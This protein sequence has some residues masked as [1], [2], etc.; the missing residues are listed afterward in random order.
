M[1]LARTLAPRPRLLLCDEPVSALDLPNRQTL[2]ERLRAVQHSEG[3]PVLYVTHSP[4]EA[5]AVGTRLF[6]LERGR[7]P[8]RRPAAGRPGQHSRPIVQPPRRPPQYPAGPR[9]EPVAGA[10]RHPAPAREWAVSDRALSRSGTGHA[11]HR[12]GSRRGHPSG[13]RPDL[14]PE[15]QN[16]IPGKVER[17]ITHGP[18]AEALI[19]TGDVTWIVSLVAPAVEQ[20]ALSPGQDVH[21]IIK[22]RSCHVAPGSPPRTDR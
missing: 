15:A 8:R 20:L 4:A 11:R 17:V 5:V 9:R 19:R 21:M 16:L 7:S 10:N 14:R 3:I 1:G 2:I 6:L 12:P 18:E 13:Q 22:A